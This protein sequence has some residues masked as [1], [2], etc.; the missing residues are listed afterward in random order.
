MALEWKKSTKA[1]HPNTS[2]NAY[3]RMY[4]RSLNFCTRLRLCVRVLVVTHTDIE[5]SQLML[6]AKC[7]Y[8]ST[9]V[10]SLAHHNAAIVFV[11]GR[12][13]PR[14]RARRTRTSSQINIFTLSFVLTA[15][16]GYVTSFPCT[17]RCSRLIRYSLSEIVRKVKL[18]LFATNSATANYLVVLAF[19]C[20]AICFL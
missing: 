14:R 12:T 18:S 20:K 8:C 2:A 19:C 17:R 11:A 7:H 16:C 5:I 15:V 9:P 3:R 4:D 13:L 10:R 1:T 6:L